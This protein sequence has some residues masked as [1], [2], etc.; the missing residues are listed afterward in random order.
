MSTINEINTTNESSR[1]KE[2]GLNELNFETMIGG[3]GTENNARII[4]IISFAEFDTR[5]EEITEQLWH[6]ATEVGFFQLTDHGLDLPL[7]QAAFEASERFFDLR[8]STKSKFPLKSGLNAGWEFMEQVRPSTGTADQKESYQV[9]LPHMDNLF[10]NQTTL[11]EFQRVILSFEYQAWQL[12]MRVL[13]CFADKLGFP[14]EFFTDAHARDS[15]H[16]QSTLRLLHYLPMVRSDQAEGMWRAGAHTDFD[17]LTMVFQKSGQGG[18]QVCP[19]KDAMNEGQQ[20]P[21][22]TDVIPQDGLI[23][24]NIGDML[25]RWSDDKLK[26]TLHRVRMPRADEYQGARYSMAYFC[27]ANKDIIIQGPEKKY[28]KIS[29]E[30]YLLQRIN[31]NFAS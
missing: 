20:Q 3:Q 5:R 9:T 19:G 8:E 12:G 21:S 16:F 2:Y 23:T 14:T 27:Q 17:C 4:P 31:A 22:W 28:A 18:L 25:M 26:S 29:A 7:I 1:S 24:C 10:P 11:P 13:S 30:D 6:A 15:E